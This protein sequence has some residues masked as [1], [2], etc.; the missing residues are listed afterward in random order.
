[1][2]PILHPTLRG[3]IIQNGQP[4]NEGVS[5]NMTCEIPNSMASTHLLI[6]MSQVTVDTWS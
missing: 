3:E 6:N 1:M 2:R 5:W 4:S